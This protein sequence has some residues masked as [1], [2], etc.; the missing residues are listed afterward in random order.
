MWP[1]L[2][3]FIQ[4]AC[5]R[6][7]PDQVPALRAFFL[8]VFLVYYIWNVLVLMFTAALGLF[9]AVL[10]VALA[11]LIVT[12][13]LV[14]LLWFKGRLFALRQSLTAVF[15]IDVLFNFLVLPA[16]LMAAES[17][18]N[19]TARGLAE[20]VLM[21]VTVWRLMAEGFIYS[22][23]A[24][25]S[26]FLGSVFALTLSLFIFYLQSNWFPQ[27]R[28]AQQVETTYLPLEESRPSYT[29]FSVATGPEILAVT[30]NAVCSSAVIHT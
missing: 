30:G 29:S 3:L 2:R 24:N 14:F 16:F 25:I 28:S 17:E 19:S 27:E 11:T 23:A 13:A 7:G 5:F 18:A 26:W 8:L 1:V 22:R 6:V 4:L 15:G 9:S 20:T 12:G 10:I 21:L